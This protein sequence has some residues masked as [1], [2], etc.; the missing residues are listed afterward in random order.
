MLLGEELAWKIII[1]GR[2]GTG[3]PVQTS[4]KSNLASPQTQLCRAH[5]LWRTQMR[6]AIERG[7][8]DMHLRNLPLKRF[9]VDALTQRLQAANLRLH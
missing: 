8:A 2:N 6:E 1:P 3:L 4:I 7:H 9:G 5:R